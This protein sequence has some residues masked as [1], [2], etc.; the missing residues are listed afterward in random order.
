MTEF[1]DKR[2]PTEGIN[3]YFFVIFC[4][5]IALLLVLCYIVGPTP[6]SKYELADSDCYM[7]LI[8]ASDL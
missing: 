4:V 1:E 3:M 6:G 8:R 2:Q 7:H 5:F